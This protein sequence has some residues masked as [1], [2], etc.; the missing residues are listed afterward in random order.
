MNTQSQAIMLKYVFIFLKKILGSGV[1]GLYG[2]YMFNFLK[3][4]QS[5][6]QNGCTILYSHHQCCESSSSSMSLPTLGSGMIIYALSA[7]LE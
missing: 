7:S 6:F 1:A 4:C 5:I 3:I 2:M